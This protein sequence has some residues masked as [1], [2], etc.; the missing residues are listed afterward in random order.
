MKQQKTTIAIPEGLQFSQLKLAR[1]NN[2]DVSFNWN[3]IETICTASGVPVDVLKNAPEDNTAALVIHWY[4]AHRQAGG[5]ADPV[6]EDL[7]AETLLE[8]KHGQIVSH[9]PGR[10]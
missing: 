8:E 6:A 3:V 5:A 1:E 7:L 4:T 2:G 10:A 9:Q